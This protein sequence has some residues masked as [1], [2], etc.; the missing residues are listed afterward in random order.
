[1]S[2]VIS[3]I[4]GKGGVGKT[5]IA[6]NMGVILSQYFRRNVTI[7]DCNV[8]T[9]HLGLSLG[10]HNPNVT[11]NHVLRGE[12]DIEE[13]IHQHFSGMRI[14][15]SSIFLS[16]MD[17][18]DITKLRE[19][20]DSIA[21]KNDLIILD[22]GPG[23]GREAVA[24]LKASDEVLYVAIP[25]V[26][27]VIDVVRCQEVANELGITSLGVVLNM[28]TKDK[29]EMTKQEIEYST[30]MPV[31]SSIPYDKHVRRSLAMKT[32]VVLYKPKAGASKE[33]VRLSSAIIG[34]PY[35]ESRF[36]LFRRNPFFF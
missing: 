13:S 16:D 10:I 20:L 23:L 22:A 5:T 24:A 33:L 35:Q 11:L 2:R 29:H 6:L 36:G 26:P 25:Y 34:V 28:K 3:I 1:M 27:S 21:H 12:S 8:T 9:S 18:V 15:P 4:S 32:P 31:I 14:I 17:R 30:N 19:K 7:V